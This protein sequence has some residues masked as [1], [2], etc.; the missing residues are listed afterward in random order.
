AS[1]RTASRGCA[2]QPL[3]RRRRG[4]AVRHA[5]RARSGPRILEPRRSRSVPPAG[6]NASPRPRCRRGTRRSPRSSRGRQGW[7]RGPCAALRCADRAHGSRRLCRVAAPLLGRVQDSKTIRPLRRPLRRAHPREGHRRSGGA[8]GGAQGRGSRVACAVR[9]CRRGSPRVMSALYSVA[10]GLFVL[11]YLPIFAVRRMRTNSDGRDLAHR[12]GWL[13]DGL[14]AEP[15]CWIHAVSVGEVAA[16][17]PLVQAIRRRWPAFSIV[18]STVTPTGARVVGREL[19]DVATHRYFPLDLPG[20]VR[21]AVDAVR[22]SF[23][24]GL[25]T[26]LWPNFLGALHARGIPTMIANGR[27]HDRSF[28]SARTARP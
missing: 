18:L 11:A 6:S 24:I 20:P 21:R 22:P 4:H 5:L 16:A 26:E 25:E 1:L 2:R 9:L 23:F 17:V 12:W 15:R 13:G 10:F 3:A 8:R 7:R 28:R 27:I 19:A 14:P